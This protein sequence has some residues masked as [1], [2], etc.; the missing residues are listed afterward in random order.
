MC[1]GLPLELDE[2]WKLCAVIRVFASLFLRVLET[3][4]V[5]LE[6]PIQ[7]SFL[8]EKFE[9]LFPYAFENETMLLELL[10]VLIYGCVE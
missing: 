5:S 7:T 10:A 9:I 3:R 1:H 8:F 6:M 2:S 4:L